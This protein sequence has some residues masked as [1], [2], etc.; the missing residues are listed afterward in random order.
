MNRFNEWLAERI[1]AIVGTMWCFYVFNGIA[2]ISLS[3]A[4]RTHS[5]FPLINWV[6]SNWLQL[7]LLPALMV[8]QNITHKKIDRIHRHLGIPHLHSVQ[9]PSKTNITQDKKH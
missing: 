8:G 4:I 1:T 7:I 9:P 2:F 5:L 3:S 6:S